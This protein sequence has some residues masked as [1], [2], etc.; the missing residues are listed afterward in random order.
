MPLSIDTMPKSKRGRSAKYD[1][2][3]YLTLDDNGYGQPFAVFYGED[4]ECTTVSIQVQFSRYAH[5]NGVNVITRKLRVG[6]KIVTVVTD[7]HGNEQTVEHTLTVEG[8]G[9]QFVSTDVIPYRNRVS[10]HD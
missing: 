8:V 10:K 9:V 2:S 7:E 3:E 4:Y 5:D 6:D 1:W